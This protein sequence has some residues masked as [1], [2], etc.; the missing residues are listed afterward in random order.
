MKVTL[1]QSGGF[2]NT[3]RRYT[4]D[5]VDPLVDETSVSDLIASARF[6]EL[7]PVIGGELDGADRKQYVITVDTGDRQHAVRT[8]DGAIPETLQPLLKYIRSH[9]R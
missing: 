2:A 4:V 3:Q 7:P 6:V 1:V 5:T 9:G 8:F